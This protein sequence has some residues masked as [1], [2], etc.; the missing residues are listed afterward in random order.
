MS[1]KKL[2]FIYKLYCSD[3]S[4]TDFYIGS[5]INIAQRKQRHKNDC[6]NENR[7]TYNSKVYKKIRETG[8]MENWKMLKLET[9]EYEHKDEL[10]LKE[11][12]WEQ[13]L[14]PTLNSIRVI[15][16]DKTARRLEIYENRTDEQKEQEKEMHKK[17]YE[18]NKEG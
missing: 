12:E 16:I 7:K 10:R 13:K 14:K 1:S 15:V 2:G 11:H 17:W 9:Y 18:E 3:P 6:H 4:I 5:T 8:G